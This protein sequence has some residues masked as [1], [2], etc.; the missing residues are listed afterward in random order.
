MVTT[1]K[2]KR[3]VITDKKRQLLRFMEVIWPGSLSDEVVVEI[4]GVGSGI[5]CT[6]EESNVSNRLI[7]IFCSSP[8]C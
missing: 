6:N 2:K 8:I 4:V 7:I 3:I 5:G 1:A